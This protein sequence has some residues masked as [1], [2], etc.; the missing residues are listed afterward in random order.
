MQLRKSS[1][2]FGEACLSFQ[3]LSCECVWV[4]CCIFLFAEIGVSACSRR[5][6]QWKT[7]FRTCAMHRLSV[8]ATTT[9]FDGLNDKLDNRVGTHC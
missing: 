9:T 6:L 7:T 8:F 1:V 4:A 5:F 2:I 3:V